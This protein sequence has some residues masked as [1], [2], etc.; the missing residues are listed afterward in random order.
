MA[1]LTERLRD[2]LLW[3]AVVQ[4]VKTVTAAVIAWVL[5][6]HVFGI[7]QP[8]LAPWAALLTVNATVFRTFTR[9]LQQVTAAVFGVLL[10]FLA[11]SLI[12]VNVVSLGLMLLVAMA[13]GRT[14]ALR[15]EATTAA[16][17]G[18]VVLLAGYSS[19]HGVLAARLLDTVIGIGVGLLIN[20]LVWPPLHDRAAARQ[21]D[22]IDDGIG[23]LLSEIARRLREG[24]A[25]IDVESWVD[26][27]RE[28]DH[29]IDA[30]WA[31][32][33]QTRESGR[34]NLRRQ[35]GPRVRRTGD[36]AD[37]LARL[38]Q[39]T[40]EMRSIARTIGRAGA[41]VEGW[42]PRFR[43]AWIELLGRT[44]AAVCAADPGAIATVR[45]DIDEAV[46]TLSERSGALRPVHGALLVNL[47]NIADAMEAVAAAQPVH[48]GA[49][50]EPR[51]APPNLRV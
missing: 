26:R 48:A 13:V 36:F 37:L 15:P 3:T 35:A 50:A 30:A 49:P 9:G 8:F 43:D 29:E 11:G 47:R 14:R 21:I 28:L 33:R 39:A 5:A 6:G 7:A 2:P 16:A 40:A 34:L 45:T 10:A 25:S 20:L 27:T 17:T 4:V 46:S 22:R 19:E 24:G 1:P 23:E 38:E 12:G 44:G 31:A 32:L 18:L 42:D 51:V 41:Q